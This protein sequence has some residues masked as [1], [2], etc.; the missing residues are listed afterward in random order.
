MS[1]R[2]YHYLI[3]TPAEPKTCRTCRA[4]ILSGLDAGLPTTVDAQPINP[5]GELDALIQGRWTY[6]R[7]RDGSLQHREPSTIAAG[8]TRPVYV[9]HRCRRQP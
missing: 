4:P 1:G 2:R 6:G 5:A 3:S 8:A 7:L 9:E